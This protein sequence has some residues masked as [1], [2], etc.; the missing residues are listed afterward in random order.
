MFDKRLTLIEKKKL[1][2]QKYF[3]L[4]NFLKKVNSKYYLENKHKFIFSKK[5]LEYFLKRKNVDV[6]AILNVHTTKHNNILTLTTTFGDTLAW[7]SSGMFYKK[8]QRGLPLAAALC[9]KK[10][11]K[12]AKK[13]KI[14]VFGIQFNGLGRG[15][16]AVV[17]E[18]IKNKFKIKYLKDVTP[19]AHNG[20]RP[21]KVKRNRKSHREAYFE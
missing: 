19:I 1:L 13:H 17:D 10:I 6:Q 2:I 4:I 21:P 5:K 20:C 3:K 14:L 9:T 11:L 8:S 16:H 15:T 18:I 7:A 12:F